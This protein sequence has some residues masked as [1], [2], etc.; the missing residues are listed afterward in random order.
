MAKYSI[1]QY[2]LVFPHLDFRVRGDDIQYKQSHVGEWLYRVED[3]GVGYSGSYPSLSEA[4]ATKMK[5]IKMGTFAMPVIASAGIVAVIAQAE[6][7][8]KLRQQIEAL[9]AELEAIEADETDAPT[10]YVVETFGYGGME[11]EKIAF[12]TMSEEEAE[13]WYNIRGQVRSSRT[14]GHGFINAGM[15]VDGTERNGSLSGR[16]YER[17]YEHSQYAE[18]LTAYVA[19]LRK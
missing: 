2:R 9:E 15:V 11:K 13:L 7:E 14:Y 18:A 5:A 10:L 16:V 6:K 3:G 17:N 1:E 8:A 4:D 19:R 12:V